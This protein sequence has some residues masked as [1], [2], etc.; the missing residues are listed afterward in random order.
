MNRD[1]S[2]KVQDSV[3]PKS[4]IAI[5]MNGVVQANIDLWKITMRYLFY[6]L[7][8]KIVRVFRVVIPTRV[9]SQVKASVYGINQMPCCNLLVL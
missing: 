7:N 8:D 3:P 4:S 2:E 6:R 5:N 1:L 9:E